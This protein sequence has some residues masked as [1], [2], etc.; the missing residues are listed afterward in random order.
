MH[1]FKIIPSL[2]ILKI[3][4]FNPSLI[5]L[6]TKSKFACSVCGPKMKSHHS[7]SLGKE[8]F[9]EYMNFLSKN[10]RHQMTKKHIFHGKENN[11]SKPQRMTPDLWKLE[12][13]RIHQGMDIKLSL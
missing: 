2:Y 1:V 5:G 12:Y 4:I 10:H 13:N 7:R 6:Q 8:V 11:A 9:D 3:G